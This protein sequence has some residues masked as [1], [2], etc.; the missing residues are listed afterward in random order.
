MI[1]ETLFI[2]LLFFNLTFSFNGSTAVVVDTIK[3]IVDW[4]RAAV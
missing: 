3:R 4:A 1:F 2:Q